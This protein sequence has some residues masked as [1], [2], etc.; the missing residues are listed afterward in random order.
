MLTLS[1]DNVKA[2]KQHRCDLCG[3]AIAIGEEHRHW[4]GKDGG[5]FLASHQHLECVAV[6]VADRWDAM[7]WECHSDQAEF[8]ARRDEIRAKARGGAE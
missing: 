1:D 6:T 7:D 8:R 4:T 3:E 5:E 2:R